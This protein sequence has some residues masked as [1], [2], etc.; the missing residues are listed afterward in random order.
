MPEK[1]TPYIFYAWLIIGLLIAVLRGRKQ[2]ETVALF[3]GIAIIVASCVIHSWALLTIICV[4]LLIVMNILWK[5][6]W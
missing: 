1:L 6:G 3:G 4:G 2:G 5:I